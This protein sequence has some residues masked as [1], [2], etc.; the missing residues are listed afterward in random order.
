M[1]KIN[2]NSN[3]DLGI[4]RYDIY[5]NDENNN[6]T[7]IVCS[8]VI[9]NDEIFTGKR[10]NDCFLKAWDKLGMI[11]ILLEQQGFLTSSGVFVNRE[12]A[13]QIAYQ[14]GQTDRMDGQLFSEDVW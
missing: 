12:Q 5:D 8:A 9:V 13:T 7:K 6:I 1:E 10:H 14:A 4:K 2:L 11:K 3:I